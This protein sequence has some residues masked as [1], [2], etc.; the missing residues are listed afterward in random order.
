MRKNWDN[1]VILLSTVSS[2][3]VR[4]RSLPSRII[5]KTSLPS[6]G[7]ETWGSRIACIISEGRTKTERWRGILPRE[8]EKEK[9]YVYFKNKPSSYF[10]I[11]SNRVSSPLRLR[12]PLKFGVCWRAGKATDCRRCLRVRTSHCLTLPRHRGANAENIVEGYDLYALMV[13]LIFKFRVCCARTNEYCPL[14]HALI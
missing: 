2:S 8:R 12:F 13:P 7:S 9:A 1:R 4:T 10:Q 14:C 11:N 6:A 5:K 3:D